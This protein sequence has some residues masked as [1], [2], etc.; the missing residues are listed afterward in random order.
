MVSA[1]YV[2]KIKEMLSAQIKECKN[3]N[4]LKELRTLVDCSLQ[5]LLRNKL[6]SEKYNVETYYC[7]DTVQH[8]LQYKRILT[9][10]LY[11]PT[12]LCGIDNADIVNQVTKILFGDCSSCIQCEEETTTTTTTQT[13]STTFTSTTT[14]STTII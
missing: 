11:N 5:N 10:K 4:S 9:R 13:S 1:L 6:N 14:S 7:S 12:Y 2:K 8:L 3:C